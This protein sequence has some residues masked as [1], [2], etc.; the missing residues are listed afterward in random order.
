MHY[1]KNWPEGLFLVLVMFGPLVVAF[2]FRQQIN[3]FVV[4]V[5]GMA[6]GLV[7]WLAIVFLACW[8]FD[9]NQS[10]NVTKPRDS[11]DHSDM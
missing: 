5:G 10:E 9:L 2:F 1:I 11:A 7:A 6:V 4:L 3:F 8:L